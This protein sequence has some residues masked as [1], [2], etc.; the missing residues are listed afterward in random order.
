MKNLCLILLG[1]FASP[2]FA[3]SDTTFMPEGSKDITLSAAA[4]LVQRSEGSSKMRAIVLPSVSVQWSNGIFLAPGGVGMKLSDDPNLQYGPLLDYGV[5][6]QRSDE[7]DQST[8]LSLQPGAFVSYQLLNNLNLHSALKYGGSDDHRGVQFDIGSSFS[9]PVAQ[10]RAITLALGATFVDRAYM[11]S[12]FGVT[13]AQSRVG[14]RPV[15]DAGGGLKNVY[16]S[17]GW[18][19]ELTHKYSL[20]SGVNLSWLGNTP[21]ASPLTNSNRGLSVFSVLSYHY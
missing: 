17:G 16:V 14:R 2:V 13:P 6:N 19:V 4:A 8:R 15:Y 12:Y 18:S 5:K 9:T 11:Q 3:Q 1:A 7:V 10:H 20:Y 21:A